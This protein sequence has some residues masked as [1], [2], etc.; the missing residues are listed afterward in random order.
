MQLHLARIFGFRAAEFELID[1]RRRGGNKVKII[2]ARQALL[3]DFKVEQPKETT[4]EA[5]AQGRAAFGFK[6]KA[7][8]IEAQ[9]GDR[10]TQF[11]KISGIG[12]EQATEHHRLHFLKARQRLCRRALRIGNR[13]THTGLRDFLDLRGDEADFAG[14]DLAQN[15]DFRP[16]TADTVDKMAGARLHEFD[17]LAFFDDAI[18]HA[19]QYDDAQIRV[20]P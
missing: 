1:H 19:H 18:N 7:G 11:F 15:L 20:I 2:F 16:H 8:V 12:R 3:N 4:T 17:L 13:V 9:L 5:K 10:L 6:R 14:T